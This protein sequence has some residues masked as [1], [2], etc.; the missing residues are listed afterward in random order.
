MEI[1]AKAALV[2]LEAFMLS[3]SKQTGRTIYTY[4]Y[5]KAHGL[6]LYMATNCT[7]NLSE[8]RNNPIHK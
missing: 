5:I 1:L 6:K 7:R 8:S 3:Y 2:P 4:A